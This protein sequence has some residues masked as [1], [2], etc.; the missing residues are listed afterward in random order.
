MWYSL[1]SSCAQY[2]FQKI[3]D[4]KFGNESHTI[5]QI[6]IGKNLY[7]SIIYNIIPSLIKLR[8]FASSLIS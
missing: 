6:V 4:K 1:Y 5:E 8:K 2:L 3:I 7:F